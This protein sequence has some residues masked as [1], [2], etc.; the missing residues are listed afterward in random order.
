MND[1]ASSRSRRVIVGLLVVLPVWLVASTILGLWLWNRGRQS[2]EAVEPAKFATRITAESLE[3]DLRKLTRIVGQR[4]C[5]TPERAAALRRAAAMIEG[6]LGPSNAGYRVEKSAGP[7]TA[8]G[9]FPVLEA[10]LP[11]GT[12][13]AVV[14]LVAYDSGDPSRLDADSRRLASALA[15]ASALANE[16]PPR[17]LRFVFVPHGNEAGAPLDE[18]LAAADLPAGAEAVVGMGEPAESGAPLDAWFAG[19]DPVVTRWSLKGGDPDWASR[20]R[21]LAEELLGRVR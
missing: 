17:P 6:S 12:G 9:R 16:R 7:E 14:L 20:T 5:T 8:E 1:T 10:S 4:G 21:A 19:E 13:K 2:E 11:G 18:A 3:G 15:I